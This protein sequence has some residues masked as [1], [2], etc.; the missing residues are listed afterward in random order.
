MKHYL[1]IHIH[2]SGSLCAFNHHNGSQHR[3]TS[4][5]VN[6]FSGDSHQIQAKET[7]PAMRR[8]D[9]IP[10]NFVISVFIGNILMY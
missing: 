1:S 3:F 5:G 6:D 10:T 7:V 2:G 4:L 8:A 9:I